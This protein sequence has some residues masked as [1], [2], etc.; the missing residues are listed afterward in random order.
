MKIGEII[1][2][3]REKAGKTI[4][5]VV[6]SLGI[7]EAYLCAIEKGNR[8]PEIPKNGDGTLNIEESVYY[9]ILT[10]GLS[11]NQQEA[12]SLIL[13]WKLYEIGVSDPSLKELMK[14]SIKGNLPL[15]NKKAIL[16]TYI[17]LKI[18]NEIK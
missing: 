4:K 6:S 3:E 10:L 11:K 15:E 18:Q 16:A 2:I 1:K 9:K 12:E 7:T 8:C 17:G 14:D 5:E 13:D